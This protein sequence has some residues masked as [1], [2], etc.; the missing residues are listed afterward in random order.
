MPKVR[1]GTIKLDAIIIDEHYL[2]RATPTLRVVDEYAEALINGAIFPPVV[3]EEGT[4]KLISGYHRTR[5][6]RKYAEMRQALAATDASE[7]QGD[8]WPAPSLDI[9]CE[10][11]TIPDGQTPKLYG[12]GFNK[13]NG[14]RQSPE[15][16]KM[17][18]QAQYQHF[19][20][21]G[22]RLLMEQTGLSEP[23]IRKYLAPLMAEFEETRNAAM[24]RLALLGWTQDEIAEAL[25]RKWPEG[26]I[27]Q[28]HV[29][30]IL[31][32][33]ATVSEMSKSDLARGITPETIA[34]RSGLPALLV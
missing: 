24:Q 32:E 19:P 25:K 11:H 13:A 3:V 9:A 12:Y 17:V 33:I 1:E 29:S 2:P 8:L 6:Y 14:L 26:A 5:A 15:D 34:K 23:T 30:R 28:R 31:D 16:T 27:S 4:N 20:G 10:F 22:F 7:A 21:C 18:C